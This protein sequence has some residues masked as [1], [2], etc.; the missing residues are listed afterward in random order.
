MKTFKEGK[1]FQNTDLV[2]G[3]KNPYFLPE[4]RE[5]WTTENTGMKEAASAQTH[6]YHRSLKEIHP[7]Q[8]E[9]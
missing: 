8:E 9:L 5:T 1:Q 3:H 2:Q 7:H 6:F 4:D